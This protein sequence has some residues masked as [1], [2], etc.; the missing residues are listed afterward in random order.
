MQPSDVLAVLVA[1]LALG[2]GAYLNSVPIEINRGIGA[3][4]IEFSVVGLI[5]WVLWNH[6]G[7]HIGPLIVIA[8]GA[9]IMGGGIFWAYADRTA[10][11]DTQGLPVSIG[12][13]SVVLLPAL[14]RLVLHNRGSTDLRLWGTKAEGYPADIDQVART[15]PAGGS[16]YLLSDRLKDAMLAEIGPNGKRLLPF[17]TY[18]TDIHDKRY[19]AKFGLLIVMTGGNMEVHTQQFGVSEGTWETLKAK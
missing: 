8:V 16:Y 5:L 7:L 15:V 17:E 10:T 9:F 11:A 4:L 14:D 13:P 1:V 12:P 19:I 6:K 2:A 3:A 18:L